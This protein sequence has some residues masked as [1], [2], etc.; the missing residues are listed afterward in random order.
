MTIDALQ[1]G[2]EYLVEPSAG[3]VPVVLHCS[4]FDQRN[5]SRVGNGEYQAADGQWRPCFVKQYLDK[6]GHWHADHWKFEQEGVAVA[7]HLLSSTVVVPSILFRSE[8]QLINVFEFAEVVSMDVLL[9]TDAAAFDRC[10]DSVVRALAEV[11]HSL[12][13]LPAGFDAVALKS[14][15]RTYGSG[16][17]AV[18]FKGFDIR[19]VGVAKPSVAKIGMREL[20]L[21][22]FAR[23][24]LAPV[25]E[26]AA[27]LFVSIGLLNWGS[28]L[29]RFIRGPDFR[30][31]ERSM[32]VL[33][34]WLDRSAIDAEL[35]LQE[36]FRI[37]EARAAGVLEEVLKRIG[38]SLLGKLYLRRLRKWCEKRIH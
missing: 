27:K 4:E 34:P 14:K 20:V 25:E 37:E 16:N 7:G 36:K 26:A 22:D 10:I 33:E 3:G 38:K 1:I 8:E 23:P 32:R 15:E 17:T 2:A 30:L 5:W 35:A 18:N 19:N 31:L 24:Y 21:F 12:Q 6:A 11:L 28:P 29:P 9:R 13:S